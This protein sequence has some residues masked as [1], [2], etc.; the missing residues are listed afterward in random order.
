VYIFAETALHAGNIV[1]VLIAFL[2][3]VAG[4]AGALLKPEH[5]SLSLL[6]TAFQPFPVTG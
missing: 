2:I 1:A 3:Q 5:L 6:A 4:T